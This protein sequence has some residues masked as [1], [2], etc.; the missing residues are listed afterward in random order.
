LH[1]TPLPRLPPGTTPSETNF[2]QR[3]T[4]EAAPEHNTS[5]NMERPVTIRQTDIHP[6]LKQMI[7]RYITH[8]HSVQWKT[9]LNL[10]NLMEADLPTLPKYIT[11]GRNNLCYAYILG[12][13]QGQICGKAGVGHA[14]V[15]DITITFTQDLC[16]ILSSGVER[17]LA[18]EQ[19]T[20]PQHYSG[21]YASKQYKRM[22]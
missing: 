13:C 14:P 12:K 20:T 2:A 1:F 11:G 7:S 6:M 5:A 8:L 22:A 10:S 4:G 16:Q 3:Y 21:G 15:A 17:W 9:L 19:P 18:T